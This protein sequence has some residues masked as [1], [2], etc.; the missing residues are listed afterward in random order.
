[1]YVK[2]VEEILNATNNHVR[3]QKVANTLWVEVDF[4]HKWLGQ[5]M[6]KPKGN[7]SGHILQ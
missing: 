2:M 6:P 3:I 7:T 4:Y 1:M 5:K